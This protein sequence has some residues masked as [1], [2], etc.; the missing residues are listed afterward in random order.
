MVVI[1]PE[2]LIPT[3]MEAV[4]IKMRSRVAINVSRKY[5][6]ILAREFFFSSKI[7]VLCIFCLLI[8]CNSVNEDYRVKTEKINGY[9]VII[10]EED[11]LGEQI[12]INLSDLIDSLEVIRLENEDSAYFKP[13]WFSIS[14][15]YIGIIQSL[16]TFKLFDKK[17]HFIGD[18]GSVGQGPGEYVHVNDALID[19]AEGCIY[20]VPSHGSKSILKYN[21]RGEFI[22]KLYLGADLYIPNL[23]YS[24]DSTIALTNMCFEDVGGDFIGATI[25]K[26]D[27]HIIKKVNY[28]PLVLNLNEGG[29]R[30][31]L[32]HYMWSY[33]N[34]PNFSIKVTVSDTLYHY[35][36]EDN[37]IKPVFTFNM[38]ESRRGDSWFLFSELPFHYTVMIKDK[39]DVIIDKRTG[40][41]SYFQ[42]KNDII[43]NE[44]LPSC[45]FFKDGY[46]CQ[47]LEPVE[48]K[49]IINKALDTGN[50]NK[51]KEEYWINLASSINDNDNS[52]ILLGKL[53]TK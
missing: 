4:G 20:I 1:P 17:G 24:G 26:S 12:D 36:Y 53:K 33:R 7:Y 8:A 39:G 47:I 38:R 30:A 50:Y 52:I 6:N 10:C 5:Y 48:L 25:S 44:S 28:S 45:Y 32:E 2:V 11:S 14:E 31:G 29:H 42:L 22:S 51:D 19:E 16:N 41:A 9:Q 3:R 18:V 21:L 27:G 13:Y 40:K 15:H 43:G 49:E 46:F 35:D 34:T 37:K 23:F